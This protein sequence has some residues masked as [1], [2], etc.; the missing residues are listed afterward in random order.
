M[1]TFDVG[2]SLYSG[3]QDPFGDDP[4][5]FGCIADTTLSFANCM[6]VDS[7]CVPAR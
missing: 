5:A 1:E 6:R 7:P 2:I 4:P 3:D